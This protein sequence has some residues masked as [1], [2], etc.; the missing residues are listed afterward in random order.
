VHQILANISNITNIYD[1]ILVFSASKEE[2]NIALCQTLQRLKDCKLTLNRDK[3]VFNQ[4]KIIFW[5][6]FLSRRALAGG[7]NPRSTQSR[8]TQINCGIAL[9]PQMANFSSYFI[10]V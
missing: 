3:C 7:Q 1:N 8:N 10:Q 5:G 2:H 4:P 6:D 9:L